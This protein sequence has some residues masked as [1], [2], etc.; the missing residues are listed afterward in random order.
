MRKILAQML[1]VLS[2]ERVSVM[3]SMQ[4]A[5][6]P[7]QLHAHTGAGKRLD[8]GAEVIEQRLD[9][10]PVDVPA[11]RVVEDRA[12]QVLVLVTHGGW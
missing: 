1:N 9:L 3:G 11:D 5:L 6:V 10:A 4:D 8:A 7:V 12:E 2:A